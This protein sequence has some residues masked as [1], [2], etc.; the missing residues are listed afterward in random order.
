MEAIP[1]RSHD[2]EQVSSTEDLGEDVLALVIATAGHGRASMVRRIDGV[3][4]RVI[5]EAA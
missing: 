4:I 3:L 2:R 1:K 5:V